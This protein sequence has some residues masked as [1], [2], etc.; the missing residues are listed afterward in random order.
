MWVPSPPTTSLFISQH[1]QQQA[2]LPFL[3]KKK[4]IPTTTNT[5][6]SHQIHYTNPSLSFSL[7]LYI[8]MGNHRFR[9]SDMIPNAWF[10]KLK[11]MT[12]TTHNNKNPSK[13]KPPL[14]S[15]PKPLFSPPPNHHYQPHRPSYYYSAAASPL[16]DPPR[17]SK[18]KPR[19]R[20]TANTKTS[21]AAA[22]VSSGCSCKA[23][24]DKAEPD[25]LSPPTPDSRA[26][27]R[28]LTPL[29]SGHDNDDYYDDDGRDCMVIDVHHEELMQARESPPGIGL[30][31]VSTR[32]TPE[33]SS[34]C[35]TQTGRRSFGGAP[36]AAGVR[37]RAVGGSPRLKV[38]TPH[39]RSSAGVRRRRSEGL[40]V[41]K[42]STDPQ[43]D[44]RESMVEMIVENN[45][46]ASKDLEELL[47][48]YLS[49]NS[50]EYH[51]VIVKVFQQIWFDL[52]DVRL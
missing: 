12:T 1:P 35:K 24:W 28:L 6:S 20:S 15:T 2:C 21:D 32:P 50:D 14:S 47:A 44:F 49:L 10:Y 30:R 17:R 36:A 19:R 9:L 25:P 38:N 34:L 7:Y 13:H 18:R 46:R 5:F 29:R 52:T 42:A 43:R 27:E 3:E 40:A 31:P 41:V 33:K 51:D 48:C 16:P 8:E 11:Y 26:D 37:L 39:R 22:V 23:V 4:N 45:I